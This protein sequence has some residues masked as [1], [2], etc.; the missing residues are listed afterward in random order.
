[1]QLGCEEMKIQT[2]VDKIHIDF[3]RLTQTDFL[4]DTSHWNRILHMVY[5]NAL[6]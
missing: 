1:M 2:A 3:S 6:I 5:H 4:M